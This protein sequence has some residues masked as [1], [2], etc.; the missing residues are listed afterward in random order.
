MAIITYPLNGI[1]YSAENAET[2]LCTRTSGVFASDGHFAVSILDAMR[3]SIGSGLAWINNDRFAGKS[4]VNTEAVT[5]DIPIADGALNRIDRVVLQFDKAANESRILLKSGT[6]ASSAVPPAIVR[7]GILYELGLYTINIGAGIVEITDAD[8]TSTVL[9]ESV[10]GLMRDGVTGIPTAQLQ[11]QAQEL[12]EELREIAADIIAEVVPPHAI[13]HEMGGSDQILPDNIGAVSLLPGEALES[14][15]DL[16]EYTSVGKSY[17][18]TAVVAA[19]LVNAPTAAAFRLEIADDQA[20]AGVVTQRAVEILGGISYARHYTV[21]DGEWAA[22]RS[23]VDVITE[24]IPAAEG[25]A[26]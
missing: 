26:F 7:D 16:N 17:F 18:A 24:N 14:G 6:P 3:I 13:N 2:Y 9:D 10:C 23:S 12:I 4:V 15:A 20:A 5:L 21:S 19:G 8:I 25:G 22:W 1:D 11:R